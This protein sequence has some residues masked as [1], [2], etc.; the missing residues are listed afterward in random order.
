MIFVSEQSGRNA[1]LAMQIVHEN[2]VLSLDSEGSSN[3]KQTGSTALL[4][5]AK[6]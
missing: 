6:I 3:S 2:E 5:Q 1:A 4:G